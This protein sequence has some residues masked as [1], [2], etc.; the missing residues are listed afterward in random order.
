[1]L[2]PVSRVGGVA[3]RTTSIEAFSRMIRS[4][5]AA[6]VDPGL[7]GAALRGMEDVTRSAGATMVFVPRTVQDNG[8]VLA[9][10]FTEDVCA[11]FARD[12][13]ARCPRTEYVNRTGAPL[14]YDSMIMDEAAMD[15]DPVYDW[16]GRLGLRYCIGG[17]LTTNDRWQVN[18]SLQRT[19][20]QGHVNR[21]DVDGFLQIKSHLAQA[22]DLAEI[23]GS[24][25][26]K[27]RASL[28]LIEQMPQGVILLGPNKRILYANAAADRMLTTSPLLSVKADIFGLAD[29]AQEARLGGLLFAAV[30]L[31]GGEGAEPGGWLTADRSGAAPL[32]IFVGPVAPSLELSLSVQPMAMLILH[33]RAM[34]RRASI[35]MLTDLFGL[36]RTEARLA[37]LLGGGAALDA[38]AIQL[39]QTT[40]TARIHLKAIFRKMGVDRQQD[41]V[42]V[43]SGLVSQGLG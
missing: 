31:S 8:I 39:G 29:P 34:G 33:D 42:R 21:A 23:M 17:H 28:Q 19:R 13:M 10:R 18:I 7:W 16:Y 32:H 15:R 40:G 3:L 36:T 30:G 11:E 6:A 38:A 22:L 14:F 1:M 35:A 12:Q 37:A 4:F 24:L 41:L 26:S 5:Y 43:L 27:E 20:R 9:G 25:R 2:R